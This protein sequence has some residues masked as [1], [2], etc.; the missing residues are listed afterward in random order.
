MKPDKFQK[1]IEPILQVTKNVI[2]LSNNFHE[3]Y[4]SHNNDL[5]R[6]QLSLLK[7]RS[8]IVE[9]IYDKKINKSPI[10]IY[11]KIPPIESYSAQKLHTIRKLQIRSPKLPPLCPF[12]DDKGKLVPSVIETSKIDIKN[13]LYQRVNI[14]NS[15][16]AKNSSEKMNK[17]FGK[18]LKFMQKIKRINLASVDNS[19]NSI[20][21]N[22]NDNFEKD[23]FIDSEYS[24]LK[25]DENEIFGKK[26]EYIEIIKNKIN[27]L[28]NI[29]NQNLTEK[30]EKIF[31]WKKI[32]IFLYLESMN[33]NFYEVKSNKENKDNIYTTKI[34]YDN[35]NNEFNYV[36]NDIPYFTFYLPFA[37]LP[38]F[39]CKGD[40]AFKIILSQI[41]IWDDK[42]ENFSIN[43]KFDEII[44][45]ILINCE[46]F[47]MSSDK[48][49]E[50]GSALIRK[51]STVK[52]KRKTGVNKSKISPPIR[53]INQN[54]SDI[55]DLRN[56]SPH[57][58]NIN[59]KKN[60]SCDIN[61]EEINNI[62]NN[63]NLENEEN[64]LKKFD[65]YPKISVYNY[66]NQNIFEFIWL[67][68]TK[69][70]KVVINTP[71]ITINIP[72]NN[73]YIKQYVNFDLLFYMYKLNFLFWDFYCINY[74]SSF[75][76]F[77][78]LIKQLDSFTQRTN[79]NLYL[80]RPHI[81]K[82]LFNGN[83]F[84]T[85]I[86][87]K[88]PKKL[89]KERNSSSLFLDENKNQ[90]ENEKELISSVLI[91]KSAVFVVNFIDNNKKITNQYI[92]HLN[93]NQIKKFELM[94]KYVDKVSLLIKFLDINYEKGTV[95]INYH[96]LNLFDEQKWIKDLEKYDLTYLDFL[97]QNMKLKL[98]ET[99]KNEGE[100]N[101]Y[102]PQNKNNVIEYEGMKKN[103]IITI[104]MK[105]PIAVNRWINSDGTADKDMYEVTKEA[106]DKISNISDENM[107]ELSKI[108]YGETN[109][110]KVMFNDIGS[111]NKGMKKT[112][113]KNP[114]GSIVDF[115]KKTSVMME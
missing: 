81:K 45:K 100:E 107:Y 82:Y 103:T 31:E 72:N 28:K 95:S 59:F 33:I 54:S 47:D 69:T 48:K 114:K 65:I 109:K 2:K 76:I 3:Y 36:E 40:E 12:Y 46:D 85:I 113:R 60:I 21:S 98:K 84:T 55:M 42:T 77:R 17:F 105:C 78:N 1:N 4:I 25:Y 44:S 8:K 75:K 97:E 93:Y 13:S 7:K 11:K 99:E 73:I 27:E 35:N 29:P 91:Q 112:N 62:S 110:E 115:R 6:K 32:S 19:N 57:I 39:Y 83:K 22:L 14:N 111:E 43:P 63:N 61:N 96:A 26:E 49:E 71:L 53:Y 9:N 24:G 38:L 5:Y 90:E 104:E 94:E 51:V 18:S 67:T 92:I 89:I 23:I 88:L 10:I 79:H 101:I 74:L 20:D 108:Y 106:L 86:T 34:Y 52:R 37:L 16:L 68:P 64:T 58:T 50:F 30:K 87:K 56:N 66:F 80:T 41:L 102:N 15:M 70:F